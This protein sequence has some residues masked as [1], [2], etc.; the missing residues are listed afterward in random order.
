[1]AATETELATRLAQLTLELVNVPSVSRDEA[2]LLRLVAQR[3]QRLKSFETTLVEGEGLLVR[4][5]QRTGQPW[6]VLAGHLDTVPVQDNLPGRLEAEVI[7]GLGTSDMKSAL[8][9]MLELGEWLDRAQPNLGVELGL[10]FFARE[11]LPITDSAVPALFRRCPELREAALLVVMEPTDNALQMGCLGNLNAEV[12]FHGKSAH[13][14]R[15][16]QGENALHQAIAGLAEIG[17]R[18]PLAVEIGALTYTEVVGVTKLQAGIAGNVIPD[19]AS[20]TINYRYA[21]DRRPDDAEARLRG[22]L[23]AGADLR[24][25]GN[26]PPARVV[27]DNPLIERLRT[28]GN[29]PVEP[30]QA[31]TPVAEFSA[32]GLDAINF[33]PGAGRYAHQRDE[34]VEVGQIVRAYD[35]LQRF[36]LAD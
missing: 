22:W 11:E 17:R 16:W 32:E 12:Q 19:L 35:I 24:V 5:K 33:G 9:V 15:P 8:A 7:H 3:C 2:A 21:P 31:W 13:S 1:M 20:A 34:Q 10:L 26:A 6:I 23:P 18:E 27:M 29:L 14:A 4:Q 25:I 36:L 28:V 30:K